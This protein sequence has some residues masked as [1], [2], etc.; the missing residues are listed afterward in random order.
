[1][2]N[3]GFHPHVWFEDSGDIVRRN[4]FWRALPPMHAGTPGARRWT[5]T[6]STRRAAPC[7][8]RRR[9]WPRRSGMDAHSI[10]ADAMFVDPAQG[11]YRVKDG[12]P[13]LAL[14]FVNF[15]MDQF[16]VTSPRLKAKART[17]I[18]PGTV[19]RSRRR[20]E[21]SLRHLAGSDGPHDR[22][23]GVFDLRCRPGGWRGAVTRGPRR[24][25]RG[26]GGL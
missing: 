12:S 8:A 6:S 7:R 2:V 13:A 19:A 15:P 3:N 9:G 17:P 26:G 10:V 24:L 23:H 25:S 5:T 11:D 20:V 1:M 18:M 16:G 14:G 21:Q 22:G 4:I